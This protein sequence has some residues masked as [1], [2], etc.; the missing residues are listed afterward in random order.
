MTIQGAVD[1]V[2]M[3]FKGNGGYALTL[4]CS[5]DILQTLN[6]IYSSKDILHGGVIA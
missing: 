6:P 3:R 1:T 4:P 5:Q 2:A